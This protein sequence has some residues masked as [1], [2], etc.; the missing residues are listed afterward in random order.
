ME[1]AD[2]RDTREKD[3]GYWKTT[4]ETMTSPMGLLILL[5]FLLS[6]TTVILTGEIDIAPVAVTGFSHRLTPYKIVGH[7]LGSVCDECKI[8]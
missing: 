6:A 7:F 5:T 1:R 4:W 2:E 8:I 3:R